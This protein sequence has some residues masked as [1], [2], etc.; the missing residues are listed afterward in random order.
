MLTIE[1]IVV[2]I[3]AAHFDG[4]NL[5]KIELPGDLQDL[6]FRQAALV[7]LRRNQILNRDL[8]KYYV[9]HIR[10]EFSIHVLLLY[11]P[12]QFF[13]RSLQVKQRV[14]EIHTSL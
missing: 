8:L 7:I 11:G 1:H 9:R 13:Y 12:K 3:A 6:R 14:F 2:A 10:I 5:V 4:V